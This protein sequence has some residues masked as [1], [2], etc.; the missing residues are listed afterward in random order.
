M[1]ILL[2]LS[3]D[4]LNTLETQST[5]AGNL[6]VAL[7]PARWIAKLWPES[8]NAIALP[9]D[10]QS[11][12]S[13]SGSALLVALSLVEVDCAAPR[14][15]DDTHLRLQRL[16][17]Q[18]RPALRT[19]GIW[20][21]MVTRLLRNLKHAPLLQLLRSL[22]G[23][24]LQVK[25]SREVQFAMSEALAGILMQGSAKIQFIL[26][27]VTEL[28]DS[29]NCEGL[30]KELNLVIATCFVHFNLANDDMPRPLQNTAREL[31]LGELKDD[32]KLSVQ[33]Q[34][35]I[36]ANDVIPVLE[37]SRKRR[38]THET[39]VE[40]REQQLQARLSKLLPGTSTPDLSTMPKV[41][42]SAYAKLDL[43]KQ[44]TVWHAIAELA[45]L[46]QDITPLLQTVSQLVDSPELQKSKHLRVISMGTVQACLEQTTESSHLDLGNSR[47]GQYCL[48]SLQS[49]LREL[50]LAAG[51]C[52]PAFL[53][54][55]L[56]DTLLSR[57]R[58]IAFQC[59]RTLSDRN[60]ASELETLIAAWGSVAVVSHDK[61]LNLALLQ[62]V[63]ML[64]H[65]NSLVC[66]LAFS[67][68]ENVA[69][70]KGISAFKLFA[71][72]WASIAV[73]VVLEIHSRP[74]KTQ[75]LCAILGLDVNQFLTKT[76]G[77]TV[78]SLVL[79]RKK[80]ILQRLATARGEGITVHDLCLQPR[81]NMAA[82]L[83]LLLS[84]P[85][86]NVEEAAFQ[87]LTEASSTFRETNLDT[88]VQS[89]PTLI[90][91]ELLKFIG[92]QPEERKSRAYQA[93]NV[94]AN[95]AERRPG[96]TKAHS[97][98]SKTLSAFFGVHV[99][100]IMTSFSLVLASEQDA[101]KTFD[102]L[103]C[104]WGISEMVLLAREEVTIALPQ[105]RACL[106]HAIEQPELC[107][108]AWTAWLSLL[109][110]LESEDI[111]LIADQTFALIIRYWDALSPD[112]QQLTH[113][114]IAEMIKVHNTTINDIVMLLPSLSHIPLLSK[115]GAEI[116]RLQSLETP[117]GRFKAFAKRLKGESPIV[118]VQ[119]LRELVLFLE[120]HQGLV[121]DAA[122]SE[123]PE[124][125]LSDLVRALLDA[126]A[127][128]STLR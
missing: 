117:E 41:A 110:N 104:L 61:E 50:R 90:A 69:Q 85:S 99:L 48:R 87:C 5:V 59:L 126:T 18:L 49:S 106:Q 54:S 84:Q 30:E 7:P 72:Y 127:S 56:P 105:I 55:E 101:H 83:T 79:Y 42:P 75:Q 16:V 97:K 112:S 71:P 53:R 94:F 13:D 65:T 100:G 17:T 43:T 128:M 12:I 31:A 24:A 64:G 125:W 39:G 66:G 57:N 86:T 1:H 62:L 98:S 47:L 34:N 102:K 19:P 121:H 88:L 107:E 14:W 78:P 93:F 11:R 51:R 115:F 26:P 33:C 25:L 73:S 4:V 60:I 68:I 108:T 89:D 44:E 82:I 22:L 32:G 40:H 36:H 45:T 74:Q 2:T 27:A 28:G 91:C 38:K 3:I 6:S 114:R 122:V 113:T 21:G 120:T 109:P 116:E 63:D 29:E 81:S 10:C 77:Y 92:E 15:L 46:G 70:S 76:E 58:Q 111:A 95:L 123:Q 124:Q 80:D 67:E 8:Q 35:L 52:L 118:V 20:D 9:H 96:Q 37:T 119:A 23:T 103:R